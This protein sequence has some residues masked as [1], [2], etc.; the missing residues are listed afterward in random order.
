MTRELFQFQ[1]NFIPVLILS[2]TKNIVHY[3]VCIDEMNALLTYA[4]SRYLGC[5]VDKQARDL[6]YPLA[7][8]YSLTTIR[9]WKACANL[10]YTV[11]ATQVR[12]SHTPVS[13]PTPYGRSGTGWICDRNCIGSPNEICGGAYMNSV[14]SVCDRGMYGLDCNLK[15]PCGSQCLCDRFN[16]SEI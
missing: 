3:R 8:D 2:D 13:A 1:S 5:Y 14:Y 6:T 9:C 12:K 15:C 10:N 16:G 11:F 7:A 4:A